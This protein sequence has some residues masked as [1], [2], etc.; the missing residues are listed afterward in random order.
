MPPS[1][2]EVS[3]GEAACEVTVGQ[4][5]RGAQDSTTSGDRRAYSGGGTGAG[6]GWGG[7][8]GAAGGCGHVVGVGGQADLGFLGQVLGGEGGAMQRQ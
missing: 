8:T 3:G 1:L 2:G 6:W 4:D 7:K 5:G